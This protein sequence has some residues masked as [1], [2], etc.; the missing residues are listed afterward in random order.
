MVIPHCALEYFTAAQVLEEGGEDLVVENLV[1]TNAPDEQP[2]VLKERGK[3]M[4]RKRGE[5]GEKTN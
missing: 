5:G 3:E 2:Q 4:L 1:D